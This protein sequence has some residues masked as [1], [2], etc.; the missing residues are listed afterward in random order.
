MA[1]KTIRLILITAFIILSASAGAH[2]GGPFGPPQP[3]V[4]GA[5]GLHTGIGYWFHEDRY[6]D[7]AD[8]LIRQNQIYSELG[9]G[10]RNWEVY[11]RLGVSD[12]KAIDA[13]N[14]SAATTTVSRNDLEEHWKFFGTL[15]AKGF[16]P[17]N[18][19]FGVGA[20]VQGTC[21]FSDYTDSVSGNRGGV[22][23]WLEMRVK[24]LW[25]VNAGI[26]FQATLPR[27]IRIYAGPYAV[28]SEFKVTPSENIAGL[29]FSSGE[30]T[31][32]N[33]TRIGGFCGI[34]IPLARGFRLGVEGQYTERIS[35]GAAVTY[36]Y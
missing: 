11:G 19:T 33:K 24:N 17:I 10:S 31:L 21:H 15:G 1:T 6:R 13:F 34:E 27:A 14:S 25:D 12:L 16:Y 35:M 3:I 26:G 8:L 32:N 9:Y 20:F 28:Y 4:K 2:A 30:T 22:P 29:A 7:G 5:A 23:Y 18:E 36:T